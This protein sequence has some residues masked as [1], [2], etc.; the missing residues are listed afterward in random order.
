[1]SKMNVLVYSGPGTTKMCVDQCLDTF[2]LLFF[3][4]YSV[5]T[6]SEKMLKEQPWESKTAI[7]IIPG[8][9][10][11]PIC[12]LFRGEI[13][14]R[15]KNFVTKGG[16]FIGICS[17][18]YYSTAKC[19]FE[20]GNPEMEVSGPR[21]LKFFPGIGRGAVVKGFNYGTEKGTAVMKVKVDTTLLPDAPPVAHLYT[22]GGGIFV[23]AHK[24]ANVKILA[25]Y[26]DDIA[27]E[28]GPDGVKASSVLCEVGR[29]KAL[30]FGTHPEFNPNLL[31]ENNDVASFASVLST[32]KNTNK[33][34][35]EFLRATLK[36]LD[37]NVNEKE[38]DRPQLK[39]MFLSSI[40]GSAATVLVNKME[41][42]IGYQIKNIVD[43]GQDKFA[44]SKSPSSLP[45]FQN[46]Y[47]DD[48]E[49]AIKQV[50]L[51][52]E[53]LPSKNITPYFDMKE[54]KQNLIKAYQE[55]EQEICEGSI[56]NTFIYSEVLTSTSVL[57]YSNFNWLPLLPPG[58]TI[59]GTIQVA[60]K[61]RSG[62]NW[63]N[64][65]GVLAVSTHHLIPIRHA[66]VSPI[67]FVQYLSAMAFTKA[68]LA[69]DVGYNEIPVK[70][71]WPNDVYIKLPEFFGKKIE[72]G[73]K[74]VT[75]AKIGGILVNTNVVDKNYILTVGS[76]L[77]V[78][79]AAPT[80][81]VNLVINAMNEYNEEIGKCKRLDIIRE[82]K[83]LS[84]Y[85][86]IFNKMFEQ[87]KHS[88]FKP[89]LQDYYKLWFHSNQIVTLH[90]SKQ[91]QIC[92]ITPDWG[93]LMARDLKTGEMYE[94]QPDGNSFD[95]F[96]GLIFQK[97]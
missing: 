61:G 49:H 56:G 54:F 90:G 51:C 86:A 89:F 24:Y 7:L 85:L 21:E 48:P 12:K 65:K 64:P 67:V 38:Y 15:I 50:I 36:T 33:E 17:G 81:S 74:E 14:N 16:K 31:S 71:K 5:S 34:R 75:H 88:G 57:M 53:E 28:D 8:G 97:R 79:N 44:V 47:F 10:D 2:K 83:L 92:G 18:G 22:N 25:M 35:I 70:I 3:P 19:E 23:D 32:L 59:T 58:F 4:Y 43:V 95:I 40:R 11:L 63:V 78:S 73:S 60:G 82:E 9:A 84:K 66:D 77:N 26:D 52:D 45:L 69:Y 27:V 96:N 94:L 68:I 72:P 29:G 20:M 80:T 62:N 1:M 39:P 87:F 6:A 30:L 41:D 46:K 42:E 37:V 13:N 76:G 91:A 55:T 93:L